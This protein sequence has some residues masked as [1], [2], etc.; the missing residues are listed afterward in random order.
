MTFPRHRSDEG[1]TLLLF[2]RPTTRGS[3]AAGSINRTL[4]RALIRL[5]PPDLEFVEIP[6]KDLPLYNS[7]YDADHPPEAGAR[8]RHRQG[9]CRPLRLARVQPPA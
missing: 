3:L 8:G 5:A 1:A 4:S 9:R 7:D 2:V 6:I